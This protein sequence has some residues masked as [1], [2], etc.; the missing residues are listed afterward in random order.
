WAYLHIMARA[1][2]LYASDPEPAISAL[3]PL[4]RDAAMH[5]EIH[6]KGDSLITTLL[7]RSKYVPDAAIILTG[8]GMFVP[9]HTTR[10]DVLL[11]GVHGG[12]SPE[13]VF[14]P[15]ITLQLTPQLRSYLL[16]LYGH[17]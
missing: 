16:E 14:T 13:E 2:W 12:R 1:V 17:R 3:E 6:R 9:F 4:L 5:Y 7:G 11:Y 8:D 15:F 10:S